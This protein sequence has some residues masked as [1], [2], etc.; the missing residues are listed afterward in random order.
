MND[1]KAAA[2][3]HPDDNRL[4]GACPQCGSKAGDR[5]VKLDKSGAYNGT[6][7]LFIHPERSLPAPD[8]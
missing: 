8:Q 5:C 1:P 6:Y 2:A 3:Y 7:V 4:L